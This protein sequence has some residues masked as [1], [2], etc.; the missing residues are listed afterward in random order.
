MEKIRIREFKAGDEVGIGRMMA[1]AI[2]RKKFS[3][4]NTNRASGRKKLGEWKKTY[5]SRKSCCFVAEAGDK[6]V[7]EFTFILGSGRTRCRGDCGCS[8]DPD[9]W[10]WGI[11][12][13]LLK[14]A[15][16]K[17]KKLKLK[18]LEGEVVVKN[19]ASIK[20]LE[21]FGFKREGTKRK[22]FLSDDGKYLDTYIYGELL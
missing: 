11:G 12:C 18:R 4:L 10:R 19:T 9:Y 16:Q 1:K 17:A 13:R 8:V 14:K 22:D 2:R 21:K 7:G 6:I 5:L 3:L 15:I 20:L